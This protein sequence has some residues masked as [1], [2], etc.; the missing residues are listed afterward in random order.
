MEASPLQ[1]HVAGAEDPEEKKR[2]LAFDRNPPDEVA[3]HP[4]GQHDDPR[5]GGGPERR[6]VGDER[7]EGGHGVAEQVQTLAAGR[8]IAQV[9][10]DHEIPGVMQ[11]SVGRQPSQEESGDQQGS[12]R[13][14]R[15]VPHRLARGDPRAGRD[16]IRSRIARGSAGPR[17]RDERDDAPDRRPQQQEDRGGDHAHG[18]RFPEESREHP[19]HT[20]DEEPEPARPEPASP[21]RGRGRR[22]VQPSPEGQHAQKQERHARRL[23]VRRHE[24]EPVVEEAV[25]SE[26]ERAP[27][28]RRRREQPA[29]DQSGQDQRSGVQPRADHVDGGHVP[30]AEEVEDRLV[31]VEAERRLVIPGAVVENRSF[32]QADG[33]RRVD[34]LVDVE[35]RHRRLGQPH[36]QGGRRRQQHGPP[37]PAAEGQPGGGGENRAETKGREEDSG[38]HVIFYRGV[39]VASMAAARRPSFFLPRRTRRVPF[40]ESCRGGRP[41]MSPRSYS[42]SAALSL[43]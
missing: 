20:G 34:R 28:S 18:A 39:P 25:R 8:A 30:G 16:P 21:A 40:P 7:G 12:T 6:G 10:H 32:L 26:Q 11:Q 33:D 22:R 13:E 43:L 42:G 23:V 4:H 38:V 19:G 14:R 37:E 17:R 5:Q 27:R 2:R 1:R 24:L 15:D 31:E 3:H 36:R 9:V 41:M 29:A 35:D